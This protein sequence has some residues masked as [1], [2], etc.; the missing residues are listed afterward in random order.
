MVTLSWGSVAVIGSLPYIFA[1]VGSVH[2][3]LNALF[4]SMSGFTTTG[5]TV[6]AE[7]SLEKHGYAMLMW[8]QL[9]QWLGGMGIVVLAVA[10]LPRLSVGGA[11]LM[12][13]EAPGPSLEKITPRI[14][15]TAQR[16]WGAYAGLTGVMV[17]LL[18][19]GHYLGWAPNIDLYQAFAHAFTTMPTGGFSP[20]GDSIAG[21]SPYVQWIMIPF[22]TIAGTNFVLVWFGVTG[23]FD[24][25]FRDEEWKFYVTLLAGFSVLLFGILFFSPETSFHHWIDNLRHALFQVVSIVTTTGYVSANYDTWSPLAHFFLFLMMFVG[26]CAGSTGGSIKVIRWLVIMKS[27]VRE[28]FTTVHPYSVRPLRQGK[29]ILDEPAVRGI[30]VFVLIYLLIFTGGTGLIYL[31]CSIMGPDLTLL[32][33]VGASASTLGNVGPAFHFAGPM[34][35][36]LN[37][38]SLSKL[39]MILMMWMGRLEIITVFVLF[40]RAYWTS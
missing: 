21:F 13:A 16:L 25:L 27:V 9:S 19:A 6:L 1:G 28:I 40:S 5:A 23:R 10:I 29:N 37:F 17:M 7:I 26:G 20:I 14:A 24:R 32:E 2:S 22:M 36:Y 8:R 12:Q 15:E 34:N 33:T 31:E 18:F 39:T 11:Q 35:N 3:P 38:P 4:E 30:M